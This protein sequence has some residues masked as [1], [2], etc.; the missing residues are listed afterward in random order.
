MSKR[1]FSKGKPSN[2]YH[3]SRTPDSEC[4]CEKCQN[5]KLI[6][7]QLIKCNVLGIHS[8]MSQNVKETN[9]DGQ[10][11]DIH[12]DPEIGYFSCITRQCKMCGMHKYTKKYKTIKYHFRN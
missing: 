5:I 9:C 12:V 6:E 2:V 7:L 11:T 3:L 10:E 4:L 1:T 8:S